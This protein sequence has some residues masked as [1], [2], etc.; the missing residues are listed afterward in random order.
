MS[1]RTTDHEDM[2]IAPRGCKGGGA[3]S[4]ISFSIDG[5]YASNTL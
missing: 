2:V 1:A 3:G 5:E 4:L